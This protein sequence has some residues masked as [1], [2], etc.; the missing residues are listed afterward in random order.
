MKGQLVNEYS[1][2]NKNGKM[3]ANYV[4]KVKG[5]DAEVA[6]FLDSDSAKTV[7][8][9]EGKNG[10]KPGDNLWI[11]SRYEGENVE[12]VIT[13]ANRVAV[14]TTE[15]RK[16]IAL[17]SRYGKAGDAIIADMIAK[18]MRKTSTEAVV[19]E[20]APSENALDDLDLG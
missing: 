17:A 5:T 12:L 3:Q 19:S 9:K 1:K 18:K 4:Y 15:E 8:D 7:A 6:A 20:V 13:K 16:L 2:T 10:V 14:D 11:T